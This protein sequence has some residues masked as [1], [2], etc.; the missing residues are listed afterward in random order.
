MAEILDTAGQDEYKAILENYMRNGEGFIIVYSINNRGSFESASEFHETIRRVLD[1]DKF[2]CVLAANKADLPDRDVTTEEG[3]VL[4]S[5]LDCPYLE[6]S[7]KDA[8]LTD[9]LFKTAITEVLKEYDINNAN[10][11]KKT[12]TCLIL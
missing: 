6:T 7:A 8:S 5:N 11:P 12:K 10:K 4:A 1:K 9:T 2:P 3:S